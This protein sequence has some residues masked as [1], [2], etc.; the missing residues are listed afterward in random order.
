ME[1]KKDMTE[2]IEDIIEDDVTV[3][4]KVDEDIIDPPTEEKF[5]EV[6]KYKELEDNFNK[7]SEKY[8]ALLNRLDSFIEK[9]GVIK[10]ETKEENDLDYEEEEELPSYESIAEILKKNKEV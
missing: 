8:A 5:D 10:S 6:E 3:N 7:L 9:G 1:E 2:E 4:D